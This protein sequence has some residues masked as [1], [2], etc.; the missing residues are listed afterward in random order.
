MTND[1][2]KQKASEKEWDYSA[3]FKDKAD[4]YENYLMNEARAEGYEEGTYNDFIA[5]MH[6]YDLPDSQLTKGGQLFRDKLIAVRD[7]IYKKAQADLFKELEQTLLGKAFTEKLASQEHDRWSRWEIYREDAVFASQ[8]ENMDGEGKINAKIK[9][10]TRKRQTHY[11]DLTDKEQESD[12][13][14]ARRTLTLIQEVIQA[15]KSS[16]G[17]E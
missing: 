10:W 5:F 4:D 2:I 9:D 3:S 17:I 12:R 14:E 1:E 15:L 16:K 11:K 13:K 6:E 8:H 7:R